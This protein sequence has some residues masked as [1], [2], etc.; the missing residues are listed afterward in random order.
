MR[1]QVDGTALIESLRDGGERVDKETMRNIRLVVGITAAVCALAVTAAP[2]MA[3]EF[4]GS[5]TG[6][7]S[8]KGFEEIAKAEEG[9]S[10]IHI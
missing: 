7:L 2:A 9:L 4:V 8:G 10:L 1:P 6:K 5:K 3:H